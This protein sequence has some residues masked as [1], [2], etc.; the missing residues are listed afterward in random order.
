MCKVCLVSWSL[1]IRIEIVA[2]LLSYFT[3][4]YFTTYLTCTAV[5]LILNDILWGSLKSSTDWLDLILFFSSPAF[6][7]RVSRWCRMYI[8]SYVLGRYCVRCVLYHVF[9]PPHV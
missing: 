2:A 4:L 6:M 8:L 5:L 7:L 9:R 1:R 3:L